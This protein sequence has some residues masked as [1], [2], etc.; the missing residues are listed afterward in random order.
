MTE[1]DNHYK[2]KCRARS[3]L[4]QILDCQFTSIEEPQQGVSF[5]EE[6]N[7]SL[8]A[9]GELTIKIGIEIDG[10]V[11][12]G[13]KKTIAKDKYRNDDNLKRNDVYT[14]RFKTRDF[15]GRNSL[16]ADEIISE[17]QYKLSKQGLAL[18]K[19]YDKVIP[20]I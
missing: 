18:L 20:K 6:K 14:V 7:W 16:T 8:D 17:I 4:S 15:I 12:H 9:Y 3:I 10:K 11:G 5:G 2:A 13:T 19:T 1:S